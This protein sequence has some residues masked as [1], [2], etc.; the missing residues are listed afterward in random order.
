M[1]HLDKRLLKE[2]AKELVEE[3]SS[4]EDNYE[5]KED[6]SNR[7]AKSG[8]QGPKREVEVPDPLSEKK[9]T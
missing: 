2:I 9:C 6:Q 3:G 8:N 4:E 1:S 7:H 5:D